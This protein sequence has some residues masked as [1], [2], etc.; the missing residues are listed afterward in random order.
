MDVCVLPN[1]I[2]T[3]FCDSCAKTKHN[4]L[5]LRVLLASLLFCSLLCS[6]LIPPELPCLSHLG[7]SLAGVCPVCMIPWCTCQ[8]SVFSEQELTCC[9][10]DKPTLMEQPRPAALSLNTAFMENFSLSITFCF[11]DFTFVAMIWY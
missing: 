5:V 4:F 2:F 1:L 10:H 7:L 11:L 9:I 6:S 8:L 3:S